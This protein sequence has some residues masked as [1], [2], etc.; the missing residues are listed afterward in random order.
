MT[1]STSPSSPLSANSGALPKQEFNVGDRVEFKFQHASNGAY[2]FRSL[3]RHEI[4]QMRR[5]RN[6]HPMHTYNKE[7]IRKKLRIVREATSIEVVGIAPR[8]GQNVGSVAHECYLPGVPG[9]ASP[10]TYAY[11]LCFRWTDEDGNKVAYIPKLA[12]VAGNDLKRAYTNFDSF[13]QAI[14]AVSS[15][16]SK[17]EVL[18]L[19]DDIDAQFANGNLVMTDD[20]W[21]RLSSVAMVKNSELV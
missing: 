19:I 15:A 20:D 11:Y 13:D 3:V 18:V 14:E 5:F 8:F 17:E 2:Y 4:R 1:R 16:T 6:D 9:A 21:G 10:L 7:Q 12:I